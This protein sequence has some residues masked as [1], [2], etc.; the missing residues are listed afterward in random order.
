MRAVTCTDG[1][2]A[3]VDLPDP[4][5]GPGQ[6]LLDVRRCGICGSDLHARH[7]GDDLADVLDLVGYPRFM[8][9]GQAGVFGHEL[10]GEVADHGPRTRGR[11][12]PGTPVVAVPLLRRGREVDGIGLSVA[13]PGAYAEQVVVQ[14]SLALPVPNGLDL[15]VAA[16]TEPMA[17]AWHAVA[18]GQVRRRDTAVVLGCGP[19]GLA[20]VTVLKARGVR[21]VVASDPSPGRRALATACGA[22]VVVDPAVASPYDPAVQRGAF[23]TLPAAYNAAIDAVEGLSRL[24]VGWWHGWRAAERVG[25]ATP[26]APVVFECVGVP[27]ML[28]GVLAEAPLFSRVVVVGVCM[29]PDTLRPSL[30]VNKEL[31]LR[32]VVGYTPLEFRDTLHAL[33]EGDLDPSPMLTGRVGLDGVAGAFEAL[34]DP[35]RHAKVLIDPSLPGTQLHAVAAAGGTG[36]DA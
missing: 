27:G 32:F 8:R 20:V 21:H 28:D 6:L 12:R 14:E 13:A 11:L 10:L 1:E 9:S 16:L 4:E 24:P 25:A 2:L 15:D 7:H 18:R 19:V 26:K 34:G 30:A 17:V 31:D 5:P 33:A 29:G 23:A 22:D 3:V 36:A 35:E